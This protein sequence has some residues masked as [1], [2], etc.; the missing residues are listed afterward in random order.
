M[1]V[2]RRYRRIPLC[3]IGLAFA[4][5]ACSDAA[6]PVTEPPP[7]TVQ[8]L[9][10]E[11]FDGSGQAVHPDAAVTPLSWGAGETELFATP[12]P[13]GDASKENPSL[14]ARRSLLDWRVPDGVMNPIARPVAGYLSDPDEVFNPETSELWL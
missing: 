2:S 14:Y 7:P 9:A 11:T 13:N 6:G 10:L 8:L 12:Y 3:S 1:V 4:A 5:A